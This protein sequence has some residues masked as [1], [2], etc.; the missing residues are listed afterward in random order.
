[1]RDCTV[2]V[3][4]KRGGNFGPIPSKPSQEIIRKF[5]NSDLNK[6]LTT[7]HKASG[8]P[9]P[10]AFFVFEEKIGNVR[11][12][13]LVSQK[14]KFIFSFLQYELSKSHQI[15]FLLSNTHKAW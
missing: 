2:A 5:V 4:L 12:D 15:G 10:E 8:Y 1:M 7:F 6:Q 9:L 13:Q 11:P 14:K 3:S